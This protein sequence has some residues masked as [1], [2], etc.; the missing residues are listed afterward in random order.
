MSLT[1]HLGWNANA[2]PD[3]DHYNLYVGTASP[4]HLSQ[5]AGSPQN[6][7]NT[8]DGF[9]TVPSAG[10]FFFE[11]TAVNTS[12]QEGNFSNEVS[13]LFFSQDSRATATRGI[14]TTRFR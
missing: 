7:G 6:M 11:L 2:E 1:A 4:A 10:T 8:T 9:F 5:V 14:Y 3:I 12:L 13:G